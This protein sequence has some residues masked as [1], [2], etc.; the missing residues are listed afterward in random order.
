VYQGL[1]EYAHNGHVV[2]DVPI[3][4]GLGGERGRGEREREERDKTDTHGEHFRTT[5]YIEMPNM[6]IMFGGNTSFFDQKTSRN[7]FSNN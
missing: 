4:R 6:V 5:K 1:I 3:G 7:L 2:H